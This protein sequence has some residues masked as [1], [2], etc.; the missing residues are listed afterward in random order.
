MA[1]TRAV[2]AEQFDDINQQHEAGK[3]G[4]W[5]FIATEVMFFGGLITG[6]VAYRWMYWPTFA[7]AAQ[8]LKVVLG[9]IN[10][11]VL[12]TSSLTMALAV[13]YA[14]LDRRK[15]LVVCLLITFLLGLA[16]LSIKGLEYSKE[17][18]EH[19]VPGLN[20]SYALYDGPDPPKAELFMVFYFFMTGLHAF[21]LSIGCLVVLAMAVQAWLGRFRNARFTPVELLGLYWHFVDI[22]W[23]FLYPLLYLL[24]R[25]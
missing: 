22:V 13:H 3:L 2:I 11:G 10:T 5:T 15:A 16:F 6:L 24:H 23:V 8:H 17:Y 19:L 12:L 18:D 14:Q 7:V 21:H 20:F 1:E 9:S 25:P 4:M